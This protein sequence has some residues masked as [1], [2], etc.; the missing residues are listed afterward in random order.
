MKKILK[1]WLLVVLTVCLLDCSQGDSFNPILILATNANFGTYTAEILKA[2]G[3]NA[4]TL[5]SPSSKKLTLYYLKKF[6]LI[7]L[8]ECKLES[9]ITE[10]LL[11]YVYPIPPSERTSCF[12]LLPIYQPDWR[13]PD[14]TDSQDQAHSRHSARRF[15]RKM[16]WLKP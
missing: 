6:D 3:F 8:A 11:K 5:E 12:S 15:S 14:I 9:T 2:E 10:R 13:P 7:I 16:V 4:F 1:T